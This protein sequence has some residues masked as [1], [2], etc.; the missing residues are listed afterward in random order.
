MPAESIESTHHVPVENLHSVHSQGNML[1]SSGTIGLAKT[2]VLLSLHI[3]TGG[4]GGSARR[5][6][7]QVEDVD[8]ETNGRCRACTWEVEFLPY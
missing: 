8:D 6:E 7:D 1:A 4:W 2:I 3:I 5:C